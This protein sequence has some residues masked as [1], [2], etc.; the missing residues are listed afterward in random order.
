MLRLLPSSPFVKRT[1]FAVIFPLTVTA[2]VTFSPLA[3]VTA[4]IR[5]PAA[6]SSVVISL[7]KTPKRAIGTPGNET[8]RL[9]A[10]ADRRKHP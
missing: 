5:S 6:P 3:S 4:S 7:D 10:R 8:L 9:R 2:P 1:V